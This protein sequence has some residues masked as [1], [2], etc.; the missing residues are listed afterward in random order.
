M[1]YGYQDQL[2]RPKKNSERD[3]K[4]EYEDFCDLIEVERVFS[5]AKWRFGLALTRTYL[6]ETTQKVIAFSIL[7]LNLNKVQRRK[8]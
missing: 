6:K 7:A 2:G 5:L 4:T 1:R 3:K 8:F